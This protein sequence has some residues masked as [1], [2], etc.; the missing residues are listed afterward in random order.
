MHPLCGRDA[1]C[2]AKQGCVGAVAEESPAGQFRCVLL[3]SCQ[4][5]VAVHEV[6]SIQAIDL[7]DGPIR[8][9]GASGGPSRRFHKPLGT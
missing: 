6:K 7:E 1:G 4:H 8:K 5:R 3:D 2:A 9:G